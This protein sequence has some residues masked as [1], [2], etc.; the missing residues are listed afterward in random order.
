M[1]TVVVFGGAGFLGRR[2]VHRLVTEGMIVRVVVR[3]PDPARFELRSIGFDR[4]IRGRRRPP[5]ACVWHRRRC[6][7]QGLLT[8]VLED[9]ANWWS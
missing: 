9:A 6:R 1:T 3:H 8:S 7:F 2:L 5:G 4:V